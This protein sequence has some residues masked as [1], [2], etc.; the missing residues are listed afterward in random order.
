M[1]AKNHTLHPLHVRRLETIR[2]YVCII[3]NLKYQWK[4]AFF[5]Q[6][7][8]KLVDLGLKGKSLNKKETEAKRCKKNATCQE[9][10]P[11]NLQILHAR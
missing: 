10:N 4:H 2:Y 8:W 1:Q 6:I 7:A 5:L 11:D 9:D 3:H